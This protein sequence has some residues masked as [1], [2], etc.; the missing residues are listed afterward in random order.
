VPPGNWCDIF[1][2]LLAF[3]AQAPPAMTLTEAAPAALIKF[4][5][6]KVIFVSK[7][8]AETFLRPF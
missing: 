3:W 7:V 1:K 4:R 8:M 6:V 2:V 5:L